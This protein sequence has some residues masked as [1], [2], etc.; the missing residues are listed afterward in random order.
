M[1]AHHK[2]DVPLTPGAAL[3]AWL[4]PGAGHICLGH[5]R[6]GFLLMAGVLFLFV[7]GLL[8]GGV[9]VVDRKEDRLWF[10]AQFFCG[11]IALG[12]DYVNQHVIKSLPD[13]QR[14][15]TTSLGR[16]NEIGTLY[17]ALAGLMNL[18]VILDALSYRPKG[19]SR[20]RLTDQRQD[21]AP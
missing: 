9:D 19:E 18:V 13:E 21:D 2:T 16:V 5:N 15:H 10:I 7:S 20:R 3:L 11:P 12:T 1:A 14:L 8:I 4:W 17:C 6:R